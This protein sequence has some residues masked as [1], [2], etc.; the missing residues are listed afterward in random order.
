MWLYPKYL[1][2]LDFFC[3][4]SLSVTTSYVG[5][6]TNSQFV[7]TIPPFYR[8][9]FFY[10]RFFYSRKTICKKFSIVE[11][12]RSTLREN[13][14]YFFVLL[15]TSSRKHIV[16]LF[17][18]SFVALLFAKPSLRVVLMWTNL[19]TNLSPIPSPILSPICSYSWKHYVLVCE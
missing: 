10:S 17:G 5:P 4:N 6:H 13:F 16:A 11:K 19:R 15:C 1:F 3:S 7:T 12:I 8:I 2:S 9:Y 18:S 14:M